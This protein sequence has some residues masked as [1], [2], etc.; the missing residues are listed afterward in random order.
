MASSKEPVISVSSLESRLAS[1]PKS[2]FFAR[3]AA[4]YIKEG[5][6]KEA[7]DLCLEG[8]KVFPHYATGHL[9]LARCYEALGRN[10][11]AMLEYR[12]VLKVVPDNVP[13]QTQMKLV[14]QREQEAFKSFAE[15]RTRQLK[16]RKNEIRA[17][18]YVGEESPQKDGNV[19]VI[20]KR[21]QDVKKIPPSSDAA[22]PP[23]PEK[24]Q[25]EAPSKG[26]I[27]TETLAEIYASQGEYGEA[28]EAFRRL[29]T[30]R[31]LESERYEKRIG[32]L[33]EL[34]RHQQSQR[35]G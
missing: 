20:L 21:L 25:A 4:Q 27:V 32:Q 14:E 8:V 13:V 15:E 17:E 16:D 31:P 5:R 24:A 18:G 22:A 23:E 12:M 1:N 28:I 29:M 35:N 30:E 19:D 7:L 11:E 34:A 9:V 26:R 33:E 3:L 2:P 10:I 6:T